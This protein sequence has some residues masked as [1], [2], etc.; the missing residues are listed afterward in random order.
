M[1]GGGL[2]EREIEISVHLFPHFFTFIHFST[3]KRREEGRRKE[4]RNGRT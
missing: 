4:E 1:K 3:K 2:N